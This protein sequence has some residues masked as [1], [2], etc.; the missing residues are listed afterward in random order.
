V[1]RWAS[2]EV[3]VP[4]PVAAHLGA[5]PAIAHD[6]PDEWIIG[7][8]PNEE[9]E[10]VFHLW[11]PR[12]VG[13]VLDDDEVGEGITLALREETIGRITWIDPPPADIQPILRSLQREMDR[14]S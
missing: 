5:R 13:M 8:D 11:S 1:R 12:F 7:A 2:G 4:S 3:P 6:Y 14:I 9:R 10:Y